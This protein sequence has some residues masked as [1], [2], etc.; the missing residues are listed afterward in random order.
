MAETGMRAGEIIGMQTSD[1]DLQRGLATVRRGKGGKGR[2]APF[3]PQTATAI[4][5]Y[6]RARRPLHRGLRVGADRRRGARAR[7]R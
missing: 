2:V 6:M 5:R 4:D 3:S 7:A 1:V